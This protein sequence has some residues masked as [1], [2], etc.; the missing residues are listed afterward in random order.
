MIEDLG[1]KVDGNMKS[2]QDKF[3]AVNQQM[4]KNKEEYTDMNN[5]VNIKID[6]LKEELS[7]SIA[8]SKVLHESGDRDNSN[9]I[10]ALREKVDSNMNKCKEDNQ[11]TNKALDNA[12]ENLKSL[13]KDSKDTTA[14][15]RE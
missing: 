4:E 9:K 13:I 3:D 6:R 15:L 14:K 11:N 7:E 12:D 1:V 8:A 5:K 2:C 10:D